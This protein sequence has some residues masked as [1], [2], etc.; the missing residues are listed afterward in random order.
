[1]RQYDYLII[2]AGLFGSVMTEQLVRQGKRCLVI[3]KR[4]HV[5]GNIYTSNVNGITVHKYGAHIFHTNDKE[6]WEYIN[7]FSDF[8]RYTNS[9]IANYKGKLYNLPFNMNTFYQ[10]WGVTTPQEA[11]CKIEQQRTQ[12]DIE[13]VNLEEQAISLV[14]RDIYEILIKGYTEK[15]WG[16]KATELPPSIIKRIPVRFVF[17]NN[18]FNDVYQGIPK[19]GYTAIIKKMLLGSDVILNTDYFDRKDYFDS[20]AHTVIYTGEV[21]R[22]FNYCYGKLE[23]RSLLFETIFLKGIANYQGNAVV[24]YTDCETPYTRIIEHKHFEF[25]NQ[26]DTMITKEFPFAF[27]KDSEP[28]YPINDERNNCLYSRYA[29]LVR[30]EKN[31]Y[32]GGRLAEYKYYN[33]DQVIRAALDLIQEYAIN[34]N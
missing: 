32:F 3:D 4:S 14:G 2:G 11:Q 19:Q 15:Q 5:G 9:P 27:S 30:Q 12:S 8:N 29:R 23:Y 16:K 34:K 22:Y 33:M 18:Y 25:G 26:S 13:P 21:D 31:V 10:I 17:D 24:N 7:S 20:I 1:M 28:Y 6:V